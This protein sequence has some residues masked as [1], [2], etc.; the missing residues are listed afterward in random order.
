MV[1]PC[2][3]QP[4]LLPG[5]G[6]AGPGPVLRTSSFLQQLK[7]S[8]RS[9]VRLIK[10]VKLEI[11]LEMWLNNKVCWSN[12]SYLLKTNDFANRN[13]T[14]RKAGSRFNKTS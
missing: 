6:F 12:V 9:A 2:P 13:C 14:K 1:W 10:P 8:V 11:H 3:D 4:K 7:I 5:A